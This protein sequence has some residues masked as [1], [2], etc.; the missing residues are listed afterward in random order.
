MISAQHRQPIV[1]VD[2]P[3]GAGKSTVARKMAERLGLLYLDTGAMYRGLAYK[4]L[5]HGIDLRDESSLEELLYNTTIDL[6]REREGQTEVL[7]D[8]QNVTSHLRTPE[9][10]ASVSVVAGFARVREE[11]VRRLRRLA[12]HGGVV[13]DGRDIGTYVLPGA[14]VKFFLTASLGARARR[15]QKDLDALGYHVDLDTL[16]QEIE[17]RDRLDSTRAIAPLA[18]APDAVLI[19][20]TNLEVDRVVDE[21]IAAYHRAYDR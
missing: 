14:D 10:N 11:M 13:M 9:V 8:G 16:A 12:E 21:M 17:H 5:S 15:R 2:G 3:A 1:A 6:Y 20:T 18:K 7:L 4:A 19:D